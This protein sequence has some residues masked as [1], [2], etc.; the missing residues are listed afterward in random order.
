MLR[1]TNALQ[2]A[3]G[4]GATGYGDTTV[5]VAEIDCVE[6]ALAEAG[7]N[8]V[9][10][11]NF[12]NE[13]APGGGWEH[14]C[15]AQEE[16]LH[17]RSN[18]FD[19]TANARCLAEH[20]IT[21]PLP[22]FSGVFSPAVAFFRGPE[23]AR[24]AC[25]PAPVLLD[26]ISAA[27]YRLPPLTPDGSME[28]SYHEGTRRKIRALLGVAAREGVQALVL[29]AFG[30]GAFGNPAAEVAALFR[31]E[32]C[33]TFRDHFARVVFAILPDNHHDDK[34]A[35]FRRVLLPADPEGE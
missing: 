34:V 2:S 3:S 29:G 28:A 6:A 35:I 25:L 4:K 5:V 7:S 17:R 15:G 24:Y 18:L 31:D 9:A 22:E 12:A 14:S 10:L 16:N 32:L 8:K 33:C 13:T 1:F 20:C 26:V 21:Y 30:C 19:H 23:S 11:L 27:A